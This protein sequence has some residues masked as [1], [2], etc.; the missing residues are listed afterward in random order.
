MNSVTAKFRGA[1]DGLRRA[2]RHVLA[3]AHRSTLSHTIVIG[4]T[5]TAGKTTTKELSAQILSSVGPCS[6]SAGT[7]NEH[8]D[9]EWTVLKTN[10]KHKFCVV[11]IGAPAPG[12][13]DRSLRV[14][15]PSIGVL[16]LIER[17]HFS[18]FRS[19]EA[20]AAEKGK[21][22]AAL[23]P[24]GVA[25]LNIDDPLIRAIGAQ[26][27]G[28]V[29]SI[30]SHEDAALQLLRSD[31]SWPEPMK[32]RV[33]FEG[34][35]YDV[36]TQLH[37][38]HLVVP[39][40]AALGTAIAAGMRFA[41]AL[42][43]VARIEPPA[44]RMQVVPC[45]DGVTFVRD[46]WKAPQW[47]FR[48]PLEFMRSA[49]AQR[50]IVVVGTISD[51]SKSPDQ[52]Y[53]WAVREALPVADMVVL[54]G[55]GSRVA[56]RRELSDGVRPVHAFS[57]VREAAWFLREELRAGD[58]VLLKGTNR[59]DHLVRIL[60]DR[61]RR[62]QCWE[63]R[64]GLND[65]CTGCPRA[66]SAPSA[67]SDSTGQPTPADSSVAAPGLPL[68]IIAGLG[69][70]GQRFHGTRHNVAHRVL[71]A[72]ADEA[73]ICWRAIPEGSVCIVSLA[74]RRV[75]LFKPSA[76]M[77]ESGS[78]IRKV[79]DHA[80]GTPDDLIVVL[81]DTDTSVGQIRVKRASG[82][83]GHKGMRSIIAAFQ[84]DVISRVRVGV[85]GEDEVRRARELVL[86]GFSSVEEEMLV[87]ALK[88]C[89]EAIRELLRIRTPQP[90]VG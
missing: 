73:G 3:R 41:D 35:D 63:M 6:S 22:I 1:P 65:F 56:G 32:L 10:R 19:K 49:R 84:T 87:Q 59:Q 11:E 42:A 5:G 18:A 86:E 48:A 14:V 51:S 58:L 57:G 83:A 4:I 13:L 8:A 54:V 74:G 50:K 60:L 25:V 71:D 15:K 72:M 2:A 80:G 28:R 45:D 66:Y 39:V 76:N 77:N 69:N 36:Q 90:V 82:D 26:H 16:T 23:P 40:L 68:P 53:L 67:A 70:P 17:E 44:G 38:V 20:I 89:E 62:V 30:G 9:V 78:A 31:S 52:R 33:R 12:Y 47:S 75:S 85:R 29:V 61:R 21:L 55:V 37:G 81:D 34:V 24:D 64:C 46:D 7:G 88:N 27:G 43:A 79:L